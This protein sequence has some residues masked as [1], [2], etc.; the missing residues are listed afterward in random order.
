MNRLS[1]GIVG[2]GYIGQKHIEALRRIGGIEIV[3]IADANTELVQSVAQKMDVPRVFRSVDEMLAACRPDV[4]HV[5]TPTALHYEVSRK[6]VEAGCHL[7]C[8]K[9]LTV[10]VSDAE[11]LAEL[12]KDKHVAN[13]VNL[14]YRMNALAQEMHERITRGEAGRVFLVSGAYLQDW[15]L[16]EDDYDWRLEPELGGPARAL[17][18]I[19]SHLFDLCQYAVGQRIVAVNACTRIVHPVRRHYEKRGGTFSS[20]KGEFLGDVTV[21]NE[22]EAIVLV[23]FADGLQGTLQVSQ[24]AAGH[25][26]DLR[27]RIDTENCSFEWGQERSDLLHIGRRDAPNEV[28]YREAAAVHENVRQYSHLP[29]GHSEGW[30][31]AICTALEAFYRAIREGSYADEKMPY[32]TVNDGVWVMKIIDACLKSS[33]SNCWIDVKT[34]G[35]L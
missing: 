7:Y 6:A 18:D 25:K 26:N 11:A 20:E 14:N 21:C 3:A 5:C 9:P 28:L 8:E 13:G 17:S 4:V 19:G 12:L 2:V 34:G 27:L 29:V 32:A 22:D 24:V 10:S 15:M 31:D 33:A 16:R 35:R 23:R 30:N 1:V